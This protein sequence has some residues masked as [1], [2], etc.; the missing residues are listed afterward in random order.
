[1]WQNL[2]V[3]SRCRAAG[4]LLLLLLRHTS[5][6]AAAAAVAATRL[7]RVAAEDAMNN[8][9]NRLRFNTY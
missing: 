7:P 2:H 5:T 9:T 4:K 3:D 6:A 1:V 8:T